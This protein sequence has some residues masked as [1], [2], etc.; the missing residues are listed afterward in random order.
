[1]ARLGQQIDYYC[2]RCKME[3][4]HTV[5]ALGPAGRIDRI[6]CDY[7]GAARNYKDPAFAAPKRSTAGGRTARAPRETVPAGPPKP[8][9]VRSRYDKGDVI[10]HSKYGLG[11]VTEVRGDRVDVKFSD[12]ETRTF[13][14]AG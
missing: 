1:M 13:K 4:Y 2:G 14:H 11:R 5:A 12:G 7:C 6:Q 10:E 3:R 9:S 8:F